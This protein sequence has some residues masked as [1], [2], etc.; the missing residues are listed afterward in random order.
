MLWNALCDQQVNPDSF[1]AAL[2]GKGAVLV[3]S[4]HTVY[5]LAKTFTSE[6]PNATPRGRELLSYLQR[7]VSDTLCVKKPIELVAAEMWAL[8]FRAADVEAFHD[9]TN[10]SIVRTAIE[11]LAAGVMDET[12]KKYISDRMHDV[13]DDRSGVIKYLESNSQ[14]KAELKEVTAEALPQWLLSE[15]L[16]TN[17][18][19]SLAK[20]IK[21]YFPEAEIC[22]AR[23]YAYLLLVGPFHSVGAAMVRGDL[24]ANWRCAHR[25]SNPRD[26]T[27]DLQHVLSAS[28]CDIYATSEPGQFEYAGLLLSNGNRLALYDKQVPV[29]SWLL[30]LVD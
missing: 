18:I 24:Y 3:F 6:K 19:L 17:G 16:K 14:I 1:N 9:E 28:Y 2:T 7:Y 5:E 27:E 26:L 29:D 12:A 20:R 13:K 4:E 10:F 30:G 25:N 11:R 22:D 8:Q 15:T 23:E 21:D